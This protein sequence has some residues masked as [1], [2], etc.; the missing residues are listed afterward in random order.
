[1]KEDIKHLQ[2]MT[3]PNAY[4]VSPGNYR[5][6][7]ATDGL[8][9]CQHCNQV[10]QKTYHLQEHPHITRIT[11]A[12]M[13]LLVPPNI[14]GDR[15]LQIAPPINILNALPID[16]TTVN[17]ILWEILICK[18]PPIPIPHNNHHFSSAD[19]TDNKYQARRTNIP[20]Q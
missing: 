2:Q 12:T 3:C 18:I 14:H 4:P 1:M 6:F 9:I 10:A 15:T 13:S 20:T 8:V 5:N 17:R 11:D 19:Q 16:N 7:R